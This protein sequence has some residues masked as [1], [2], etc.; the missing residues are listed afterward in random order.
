MKDKE[1]LNFSI[2]QPVVAG[3][4]YSADKDVLARQIDGFLARAEKTK[5]EG[6]FK[7][8]IL[9]HAGYDYSGQT[10]AYGFKELTDRNIKTVILIGPSHQDW[11]SGAA[12]TNYDFWQ[13]PL[14]K[15][16]I[17][18]ELRQKLIQENKNIFIR[19]QAHENEHC[20]EVILPFLQK[21]IRNYKI[22]PI[23]IFQ[24]NDKFLSDLAQM[25][26]KHLTD[27]DLIIV[28]S[29]LSHYPAY[30]DAR[31][32]DQKTIQGILTGSV[33]GFEKAIQENMT[34]G[35]PNLDTCACGEEPIK[36]GLYLA[37]EMGWNGTLLN[38][39]NSGDFSGDFSQVVGYAA[40][41]F[42]DNQ[43][44]EKETLTMEDKQILLKIARQSIEN[45]FSKKE[46]NINKNEISEQLK[47]PQG[48]FVT[49]NKN[50]QLRGCMGRI[51]EEKEPLYQV[52]AEMAK[53]AA[54]EDTRF[55][56]MGKE[57]MK[58]VKIEISVLSPLKKITDPFREIEIGKHGVIVSARGGS[59]SAG[60]H[61]ALGG[62]KGGVFLPQ[63]AIENNWDL[64]MFMNE[65]CEHKAGLPRDI[66]KTGDID[67][68]IF[69]AEVFGE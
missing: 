47:Q 44:T 61:G 13:T 51:V 53:V 50:G 64:E 27:Q 26:K 55:Y 14:G 63:V 65:L 68:Y 8:L 69:S 57:E 6:D 15:V 18:K 3:S 43:G 48:A 4:F 60:G 41:A 39:A 31:Q 40:I 54:F 36:V 25:L 21:T 20:L 58:E 46:I 62:Q 2:R 22:L 45:E 16:E 23:I 7:M 19:E 29:D 66:W 5:I 52:V 34:Q 1:K 49:L 38:Y 17:D 37:E 56:P 33:S 12:F 28:S 30:K 9:P 24:A 42:G 32:V 59:L 11:F 67:I 35:L 10:A